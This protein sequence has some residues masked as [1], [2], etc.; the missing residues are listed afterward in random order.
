MFQK[1]F[2]F[3]S[4][5]IYVVS[6]PGSDYVVKLQDLNHFR[7]KAGGH[8]EIAILVQMNRFPKCSLVSALFDFL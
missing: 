1:L 6:D 4:R 7:Q 8:C 5:F 3:I 2:L